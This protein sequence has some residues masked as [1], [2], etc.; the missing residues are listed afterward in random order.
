MDIETCAC[1]ILEESGRR[2]IPALNRYV[3]M[4]V[5]FPLISVAVRW[6]LH[7]PV[8]VPAHALH[9]R[10]DQLQFFLQPFIAAIEMVDT[11][12]VC[13]RLLRPARQ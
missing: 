9:I 13:F 8:S 4:R 1:A 5:M 3:P 11:R 7:V 10:A 6:Y 2:S 12:Q